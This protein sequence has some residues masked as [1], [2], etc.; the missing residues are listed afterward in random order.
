MLGYAIVATVDNAIVDLISFANKVG[1]E[2]FEDSL[3]RQPWDVFHGYQLGR[4]LFHKPPE[5]Q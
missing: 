5:F 4:H 1:K 2:V 3:F